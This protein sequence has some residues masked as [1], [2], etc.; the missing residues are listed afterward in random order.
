MVVTGCRRMKNFPCFC[1]SKCGNQT[2]APPPCSLYPPP[3]ALA[4]VRHAALERLPGKASRSRQG[5]RIRI[6]D[7]FPDPRD[8]PPSYLM[9]H[10]R[11]P[12][13]IN[14]GV[15]RDFVKAGI[16]TGFFIAS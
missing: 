1:I 2:A 9:L 8:E 12:S 3:A 11:R 4:G 15:F 13:P 6:A 5:D 10:T 7:P 16:F 14:K